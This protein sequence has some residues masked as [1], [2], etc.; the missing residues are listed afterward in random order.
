M[1]LKPTQSV[2][3]VCYHALESNQLLLE[4]KKIQKK[5]VMV[6]GCEANCLYTLE[7]IVNAADV[8]RT[9]KCDQFGYSVG[10]SELCDF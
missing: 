5:I 9:L 3:Y 8:H 10:A 2:S 4:N 6:M 1:R 7:A